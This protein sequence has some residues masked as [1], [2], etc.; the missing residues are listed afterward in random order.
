M[1]ETNKSLNKKLKLEIEEGRLEIGELIVL[2]SYGKVAI[3]NGEVSVE[4]VE[5]ERRKLPFENIRKKI[6]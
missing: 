1:D 3:S 2:Q 5:I 6:A 4:K